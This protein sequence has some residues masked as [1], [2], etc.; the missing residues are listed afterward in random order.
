MTATRAPWNTLRSARRWA[1]PRVRLRPEPEI[2]LEQ[3]LVAIKAQID[4]GIHLRVVHLAPPRHA[5]PPALRVGG[6]NIVRDPSL[7]RPRRNLSPRIATGK[8]Q[9][10]R[11]R[12]IFAGKRHNRAIPAQRY[13]VA[14]PLR[15]I[16]L[17]PPSLTRN[18]LERQRRGNRRNRRSRGAL[19]AGFALATLPGSEQRKAGEHDGQDNAKRSNLRP[20]KPE[21]HDGIQHDRSPVDL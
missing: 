11:S 20:A 3:L 16:Q 12:R 14:V 17:S 13:R 9:R 18:R 6:G 7:P 19:L 15:R 2:V 10:D 1:R 5:K 21:T 8:S 4:A